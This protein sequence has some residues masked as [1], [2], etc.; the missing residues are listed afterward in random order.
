MNHLILQGTLEFVE[1]FIGRQLD[2]YSGLAEVFEISGK[3][4]TA[5]TLDRVYST[6][7]GL[8]ATLKLYEVPKA[9]S[10]MEIAAEE[11]VSKA[12]EA[13]KAAKKALK[14]VKED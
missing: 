3:Y 6:E 8:I 5:T 11:A 1:G 13:L 2:D 10:Q 12:E 9:K 7:R 14:K 4:F